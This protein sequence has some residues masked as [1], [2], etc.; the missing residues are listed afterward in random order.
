[1]NMKRIVMAVVAVVAGVFVGGLVNIGLVMVGGV[2]IPPPGG[3]AETMESF[4]ENLLS[5]RP[6]DFLFPFLAH[7]LGTLVGAFVAA[8]IAGRHTL[9]LGMIIGVFFLLGGLM[10]VFLVGGPAWFIA[11]ELLLAYLP[12]G[13]LGARL[14]GTSKPSGIS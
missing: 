2:L 6:I 1:M 3:V 12:M 7:A 13:Y 9:L 14:A 11:C 10:M 8:K 4:R 5:Y